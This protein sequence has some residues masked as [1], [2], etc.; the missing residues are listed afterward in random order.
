MKMAKASEKEIND[1]IELAQL[2]D[3]CC[4][5]RSFCDPMFPGENESDPVKGFDK[6]NPVDLRKFYDHVSKLSS[7]LMRV[8]FGYGVLVDN[9][10]DPAM[11]IL[12]LKPG[13]VTF[14]EDEKKILK[15]FKDADAA[16]ALASEKLAGI[17]KSEDNRSAVS[18]MHDDYRTAYDLRSEK[19]CAFA[20]R[21]ADFIQV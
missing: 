11:D 1:A 4:N 13:L 6:E 20:K 3:A 12:E 5:V 17:E 21:A 8:A 2:T 18:E 15:E 10:C 19:A 16:L 14:D 9:V 7:G